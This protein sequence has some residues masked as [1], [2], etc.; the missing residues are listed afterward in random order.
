MIH[1][2]DIVWGGIFVLVIAGVIGYG[3]WIR[4]NNNKIKVI[5]NCQYIEHYHG[6][7]T[8]KQIGRAV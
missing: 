7:V 5:D 3:L 2:E 8:G 4:F 6:I 1:K